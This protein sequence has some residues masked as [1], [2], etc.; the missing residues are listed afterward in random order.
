V[1]IELRRKVEAMSPR[2]GP[3]EQAFCND[4][5]VSDEQVHE[6]GGRLEPRTRDFDEASVTVGA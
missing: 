6:L 1:L 5:C 2:T 3:G 4:L